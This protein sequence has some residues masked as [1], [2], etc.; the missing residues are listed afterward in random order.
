MREC[1]FIR[2][3]KNIYVP[4]AGAWLEGWTRQRWLE[5]YFKSPVR[6]RVASDMS[7]E[8]LSS[9]HTVKILTEKSNEFSEKDS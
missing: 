5:K 2:C 6:I 1:K 3:G 9:Q 7:W 4:P 8:Y